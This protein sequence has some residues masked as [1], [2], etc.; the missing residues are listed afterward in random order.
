MDTLLYFGF[1]AAYTL[2]LVWAFAKQQS[3]NFMAFIYLVLFG[4][5]YDNG[6][7]AIGKFIGE[8]PLLENLNLL[9]FWS[10]A[11]LTPT[12]VLF[13]WGALN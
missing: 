12:L 10:H 8:G 2:I 6:I 13:S 1:T 9:R 4:L 3:R 7:I 11:F 5:I